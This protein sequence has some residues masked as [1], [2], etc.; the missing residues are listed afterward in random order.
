MRN[1]Q[2]AE[3]KDLTLDGETKPYRI[4][5]IF[6]TIQGEGPFVGRPAVFIRFGGCNLTCPVCDTDYTTDLTDITLEELLH[7]VEHLIPF[8][9]Q[10]PL[11]VLTGGEP[12]RQNITPLCNALLYCGYTVQV[13][14]NGTLSCPDFPW[15]RVTVVVSPK[16]A[17]SNIDIYENAEFYKYVVSSDDERSADGLPEFAMAGGSHPPFRPNLKKATAI[18]LQPMDNE[19]EEQNWENTRTAIDLCKRFSYTLS[20]Q[21]HKII[22][23]P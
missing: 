10:E 5:E 4:K 2:K 14:T 7:Q 1:N 15:N 3:R 23:V 18:Y 19:D 6:Y 16:S 9:H 20:V 12:F 8:G 21:L 22:N 11:V 17:F 13:E